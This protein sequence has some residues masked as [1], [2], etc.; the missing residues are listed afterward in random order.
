MVI[1]TF[2]LAR[3][4]EPIGDGAVHLL[5]D[6]DLTR[7]P[8][9]FAPRRTEDGEFEAEP[10]DESGPTGAAFQRRT[11]DRS[12]LPERRG[13]CKPLSSGQELFFRFALNLSTFIEAGTL[14]LLDEP[15]NHLHPT[16]ITRLMALLRHVLRSTGSFAVIA[17]HSLLLSAKSLGW[18]SQS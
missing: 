16:F 17:T 6:V 15:E 7:G 12:N 5:A 8:E 4:L 3:L 2:P 1:T 9:F 14:V 11:S 18:T 13:E 10:D